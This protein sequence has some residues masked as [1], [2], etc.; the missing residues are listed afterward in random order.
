MVVLLVVRHLAI[1]FLTPEYL[2]QEIESRLSCR[3]EVESL[4]VSLWGKTGLELKG[5]RLGPIDEYVKKKTPLGERQPM[6][7][8]EVSAELALIEVEVKDLLQR[9]ISVNQL[10]L[11]DVS[12]KTKIDRD[13]RS[14]VE[15]LFQPTVMAIADS[16]EVITGASSNESALIAAPQAEPKSGVVTVQVNESSEGDGNQG[17]F[18]AN[19]MQ[20]SAFADNVEIQN[21]QIVATM[22]SGSSKVTLSNFQLKLSQIQIDP[23]DLLKHNHAAFSFSGDLSVEDTKANLKQIS[24][25]LSG[26]GE[27]QPFDPSSGI[28]DPRWVSN[29]TIKK[30]SGINTFPMIEKLKK[31]LSGVDT[32]GVDLDDLHIGGE[33]TRDANT[34]IAGHAGKLE[35][36]KN[37][38]LPLPDTSFVFIAGSW[39]DSGANQHDLKGSVVASNELTAKLTKKVDDYLRK[40]TK[41]FYSKDLTNLVLQPAMRDGRIAFD[42]V[43][44][45]DLG[46]P[47]V[48]VLTPFGNLSDLLD[49]GKET[50]ETLKDVGKSLLKGLFGK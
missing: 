17:E 4:K 19:E 43:S 14:S 3:A 35:L 22:E 13:G 46:D 15:D 2:V 1:G 25:S 24:V 8:A 16:D 23:N 28:V 40:K 39:L 29:L 30:G 32:A 41:N 27:V 31:Q 20:V 44:Q 10:L 42:F 34:R 47:K 33:L 11:K 26:D 18:S 36:K 45:G 12:I 9:R 38:A 37:L 48:D 6:Q 49:Q 7:N 21:G 50:I 5:V